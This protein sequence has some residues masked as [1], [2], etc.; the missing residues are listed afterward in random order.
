MARGR[1]GVDPRPLPAHP[2]RD[3]VIV[4]GIMAVILIVIAGLTGGSLLRAFGAGLIFFVLATAWSWWKFR[5]RIR[6]RD[7][8]EAL[9]AT[10][11][12]PEAAR[13]GR[14]ADPDSPGSSAN[15]AAGGN[16]NGRRGG[17]Q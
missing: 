3:T 17:E 12:P 13:P 2:Y 11:M 16:G 15:G 7:A 6:E 8:R 9:E 14:A 10:A 5:T 4:Y 1:E